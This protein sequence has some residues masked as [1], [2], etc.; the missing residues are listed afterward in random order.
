MSGFND[1]VGGLGIERHL[2]AKAR[3]GTKAAQHEGGIGDCRPLA[4]AAIAGRSGYPLQHSAARRAAHRLHQSSDRASAGAD[5]VDID[6]GNADRDAFELRTRRGDLR[7]AAANK[8]DVRAGAPISIVMMSSCRQ[9]PRH[10]RC[11]QRHRLG[12][13]APYGRGRARADGAV[14][15]PPG[16]HHHHG[17]ALAEPQS[18][19]RAFEQVGQ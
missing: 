15:R 12:P 16:F 17:L 13:K 19:V 1:P 5:C 11:R 10:A 7:P 6:N 3:V 18:L 8:A 2:A 4:A 9:A 14:N